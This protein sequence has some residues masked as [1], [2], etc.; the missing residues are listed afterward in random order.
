MSRRRRVPNPRR[1]ASCCVRDV[2]DDETFPGWVDWG[3]RRMFVV[4]FTSA[5]F[6]IGVFEDEMDLDWTSDARTWGEAGRL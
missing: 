2:L 6:P 1:A 4:D 5:G 3:G